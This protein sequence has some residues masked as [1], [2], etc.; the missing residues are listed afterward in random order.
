MICRFKSVHRLI[1]REDHFPPLLGATCHIHTYVHIDHTDQRVDHILMQPDETRRVVLSQ[2]TLSSSRELRS[3]CHPPVLSKLPAHSGSCKLGL[4]L[5]QK[6]FFFFFFLF[7]RYGTVSPRDIHTSHS[8]MHRV[9][10]YCWLLFILIC[11]KRRT[12]VKTISELINTLNKRFLSN[13]RKYIFIRFSLY[14]PV[15]FHFNETREVKFFPSLSFFSHLSPILSLV[16]DL[17]CRGKKMPVTYF[18]VDSDAAYRIRPC[19]V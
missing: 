5:S 15:L 1:K 3:L 4:T 8:F 13:V 6:R 11:Q 19:D 2:R 9:S 16:I 18:Q 14:L 7:L 12:S 17:N 10:F